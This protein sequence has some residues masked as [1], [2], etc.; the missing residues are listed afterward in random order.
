MIVVSTLD[1]T[2]NWG[3]R[4]RTL[5]ELVDPLGYPRKK[6]VVGPVIALIK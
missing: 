1:P 6:Y 4:G 5:F 2:I 3:V